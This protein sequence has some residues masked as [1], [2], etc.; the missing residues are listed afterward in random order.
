M[1][2]IIME[3]WLSSFPMIPISLVYSFSGM[4]DSFMNGV[5]VPS[6]KCQISISAGIGGQY[7]PLFC[8]MS[9]L[10]TEAVAQFSLNN[11]HKRG[12][13]HHHFIF[14]YGSL[15]I[16]LSHDPNSIGVQFQ[17]DEWQLHEWGGSPFCNVPNIHQC[18]HWTIL[19][20]VLLNL[21]CPVHTYMYRLTILKVI[22]CSD[23]DHNDHYYHDPYSDLSLVDK[24]RVIGQIQ[25]GYARKSSC[26]ELTRR[27]FCLASMQSRPESHW[28]V[29]GPAGIE[30]CS[31]QSRHR[32][33]A[34][35][36]SD[37]GR[38]VEC[39]TTAALFSGS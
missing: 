32:H 19:L 7:L 33:H 31:Y 15:V 20:G 3:A 23:I 8:Y 16:Q 18:R 6:V 1:S 25:E 36:P 28:T 12:L 30:S 5:G 26:L 10:I 2:Y 13:K 22:F 29:M 38:W 34:G 39:Y 35:S 11:V 4:N 27:T 21:L 14:Y 9:Y 17:W 37:C 24:A